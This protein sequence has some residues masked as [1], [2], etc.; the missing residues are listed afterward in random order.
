MSPEFIQ[1]LCISSPSTAPTRDGFRVLASSP[2][3][4]SSASFLSLSASVLKRRDMLLCSS[5]GM[6]CPVLWHVVCPV[7]W[8]VF[9]LFK[10]PREDRLHV[11]S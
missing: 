10:T 5:V 1:A 6:L 3:L 9:L 2:F 4:P 11:G 8:P 7:L